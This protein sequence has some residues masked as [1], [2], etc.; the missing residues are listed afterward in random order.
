MT[1]NMN[2]GYTWELEKDMVRLFNKENSSVAVLS[3]IWKC[4]SRDIPTAI[5]SDDC[6]A[7]HGSG[8]NHNLLYFD[9]T[10]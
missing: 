4:H 2:Q 1:A 6:D 9:Y 7:E 5:S 8:L 10:A 3:Q